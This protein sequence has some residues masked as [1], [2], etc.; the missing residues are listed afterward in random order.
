MSRNRL[1]RKRVPG[2]SETARP[3]PE[4][5]APG[6]SPA[7][8]IV[9][10]APSDEVM[11]DQLDYLLRHAGGDCLARCVDCRRLAEVQQTL[12]RPFA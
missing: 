6:V 1:S 5:A 11:H 2:G 8:R 7:V 3:E 4:A 9:A 10:P 12:L